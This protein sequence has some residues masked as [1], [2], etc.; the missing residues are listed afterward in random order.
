MAYHNAVLAAIVLVVGRHLLG[1]FATDPP[2]FGANRFGVA[3][4]VDSVGLATVSFPDFTAVTLVWGTLHLA[5]SGMAGKQNTS[6]LAG[7][8][9]RLCAASHQTAPSLDFKVAGVAGTLVCV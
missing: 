5:G 2:F 3:P 1:C 4:I 6:L 9:G 7:A 8:L